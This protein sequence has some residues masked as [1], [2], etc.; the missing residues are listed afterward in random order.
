MH[1][2]FSVNNLNYSVSNIDIIKNLNLKIDN[3]KIVSIIGANNSGKTTLVKLLTAIIPTT[4]ICSLNGI[5]LNKENVL[6]Y[7]SNL[8]VVFN[9]IDD[10]FLFKK[11]KDELAYPLL[12]LGY[13]EHKINKKI[14]EISNFF[15]INDFLNLKIDELDDS[16][17]KKLLIIIALVHNPK[18]L[19][20]DDAFIDMN[21]NDQEFMLKKLKELNENGLTIL[22]ITSKLDTIFISDNIYILKDGILSESYTIDSLFNDDSYLKKHNFNIPFIIDLSNKLRFYKL[23]DK[24][25]F[26]IK[27]LEEKLWK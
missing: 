23:I 27:E 21:P 12:N 1:N 10:Q 4:D 18:L 19:I 3:T 2:I 9:E 5:S 6:T 20:L 26:D 11:V 7:I 17:K 13:P 14:N 25:Y 24:V 15:E 22:N 8:G 16:S